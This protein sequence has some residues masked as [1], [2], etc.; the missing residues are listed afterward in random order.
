M[1]LQGRTHRSV[2]RSTAREEKMGTIMAFVTVNRNLQ[3]SHCKKSGHDL[4]NCFKLN[5]YPE[6]W[7]ERNKLPVNHAAS[8]RGRT[9]STRAGAEAG[10]SRW[11]VRHGAD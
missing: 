10:I 1:D 7:G 3:C 9:G 2:V 11:K 6:W 4:A 8:G 5:G